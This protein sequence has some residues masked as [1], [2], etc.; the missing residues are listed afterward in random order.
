MVSSGVYRYGEVPEEIYRELMAAESLGEYFL[1]YINDQ[2][3]CT[4]VD[5]AG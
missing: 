2:Y 5:D 1:V 4:R 3:P